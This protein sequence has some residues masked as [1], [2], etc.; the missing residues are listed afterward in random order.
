M[1]SALNAGVIGVSAPDLDS[2]LKAAEVGGF[3]GLEVNGREIADLVEKDGADAV[4]EKFL[5]AHKIPAAFGLTAN[6]RAEEMDAELKT[7][8]R[9]AK[10][11][12]AIGADRTFT[13]IMPA[14]NDLTF[15]QN[16]AYHKER[17]A[18]VAKVLADNGCQFGLEFIGPKT[19]RDKGK[20]PFIY[21]V[22]PMLELAKEVG[23]NV[24]LMLDCWH[25]HTSGGVVADIEK[26]TNRDVVDVHVNDAPLGVDRDELIDSVR[27]VPA[28][29]GVIDSEGFM[30][31][32]K[33]IGYAG[34]ITPEPFTS[35][36]A[37]LA[38]DEERL[39]VVSEGVR[40]LFS[41]IE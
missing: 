23:P 9:V 2:A 20:Y 12:A 21:Q 19:V 13:W 29:T 36:L 4:R 39:R 32:L 40:K 24:G 1:Y 31:V 16:Y 37:G 35:E 5:A 34:P 3:D 27:S 26:L 38:S 33:K 17:L 8:D 11:C 6:W 15:D 10:A 25:W 14:S 18:P 30:K 28:S 22:G 41:F 7:L